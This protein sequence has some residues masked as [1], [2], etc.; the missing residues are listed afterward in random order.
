MTGKS[1]GGSITSKDNS[2]ARVKAASTS[3]APYPLVAIS[4]TPREICSSNSLTVRS[5]ESGRRWSNSIPLVMC[6]IAS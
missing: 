1:C 5:G 6:V 4:G 2:L 3:G